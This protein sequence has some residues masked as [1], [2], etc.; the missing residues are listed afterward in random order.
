MTDGTR[1]SSDA[2][3]LTTNSDDDGLMS[4]G[5]LFQKLTPETGN[6]RIET[7][8]RY[9]VKRS[10]LDVLMLMLMLIKNI[11]VAKTA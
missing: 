2:V 11:N 3:C 4:D 7:R 1:K 8:G 10:G 6:A 9:T 5:S